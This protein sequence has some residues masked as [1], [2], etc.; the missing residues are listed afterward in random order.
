MMG[1]HSWNNTCVCTRCD[2]RRGIGHDIQLCKCSI[3]GWA[4]HD[5]EVI[6]VKTCRKGTEYE[7]H[8]SYYN[9]EGGH[10]TWTEVTTTEKCTKC[11]AVLVSTHEKNYERHSY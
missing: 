9:T 6:K 2:K 10:D 11:G 3:C 4:F 5:Y 7:R 8:G 1:S